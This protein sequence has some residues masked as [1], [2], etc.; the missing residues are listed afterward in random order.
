MTEIRSYLDCDE[1][2]LASG[3]Q[4]FEEESD[5]EYE[6]LQKWVILRRTFTQYSGLKYVLEINFENPKPYGDDEAL[7]FSSVTVTV[8]D[9]WEHPKPQV[10]HKYWLNLR[11]VEGCAVCC[12]RFWR[13][14][15]KLGHYLRL[16][17]S[18]FSCICT[19]WPRVRWPLPT[20]LSK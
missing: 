20:L 17:A 6:G 14:Y 12:D 7:R 8:G 18:L 15:F 19:A 4:R 10:I 16:L 11:T 13:R 2:L 3:F 5:D 1:K 9:P